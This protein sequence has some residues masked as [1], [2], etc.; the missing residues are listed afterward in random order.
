MN[1]TEYFVMDNNTIFSVS[2]PG[3]GITDLRK[4]TLYTIYYNHWARFLFI[5][6]LPTVL[7]IYFNY[8]VKQEKVA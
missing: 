5:G 2:P 4:N 6:A 3:V 1:G 8:K 7:L